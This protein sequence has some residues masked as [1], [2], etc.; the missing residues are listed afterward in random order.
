MAYWQQVILTFGDGSTAEV[1]LDINTS[2]RLEGGG[3]RNIVYF[4]SK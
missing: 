4:N 1:K 3:N 2:K